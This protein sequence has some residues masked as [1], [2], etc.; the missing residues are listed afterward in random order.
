MKNTFFLLLTVCFSNILF[1]QSD[2]YAAAMEKNI[3]M[4]DSAMQK[5]NAIE[6]ANNFERIGDAEKT[7]WLAYYYAS[8][9]TVMKA[10]TEEDKTKTDAIADK[11]DQLITKA[12]EILGKE[13][14]ETDVVKSMIASAHMMVDPQTRWQ[15][16]G[17]TSSG[18]IEKA[19]QLDPTNPRP[20]FL[21]GQAKFYT[22]EA[23][24]GGKA[25]AKPLFEKALA[26]FDTFKAETP[27]HPNWGK[28]ATEYFLSLAS[29]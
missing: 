27:L 8:Y 1:A 3:S 9:C 20:V 26:M 15:Q 2:K 28:A 4:L 24:G 14:S 7:Q 18:N 17:Q 21:E 11:A 25:P 16:Y 29:K 23:F 19:K 12:E 22:P 6:L 10:F 13:N 5:G